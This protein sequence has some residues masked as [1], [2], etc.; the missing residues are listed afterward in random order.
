MSLKTQKILGVSITS[1]SKETI[2]EHLEKYLIS[3][4][5]GTP[6]RKKSPMRPYVVF[7]PNA[8]QL[9]YASRRS[10]FRD[11][12]NWADLALPDST[13]VV[14]ASH[15]MQDGDPSGERVPLREA[16]AGVDFMQELVRRYSKQGVRIGLIGGRG[17][18]AVKAFE[19]LRREF[20]W[21]AGWAVDGPDIPNITSGSSKV[22]T[23]SYFSELATKIR[24]TGVLIVFVALGPP[25]QELFIRALAD[26]LGA[27]PCVLMAVGGSFAMISGA[28][29]RAPLPIR[30]L[31]MPFFGGTVRG[32]WVWRLWKEPWRIVRQLALVEFVLLVLRQR[33]MMRKYL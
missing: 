1:D 9:V 19:C 18:L 24:T 12:L 10:W 31:R 21:L 15:I 30:T 4:R 33:F 14:W 29:P 26:R 22:A 7:T 5:D 25:K 13:G 20:P 32:E 6:K 11:L 23:T 2:L 17:G 3:A 28:I 8:E 27:T 16:I